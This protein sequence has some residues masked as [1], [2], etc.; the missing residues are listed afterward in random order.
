MA[1]QLNPKWDDN[2]I[3]FPRLLAEIAAAIEFTP[4]QDQALC[5]AMDLEMN[6]VAELFDRAQAE[7]DQIKADTKPPTPLCHHCGSE[8]VSQCRNGRWYCGTCI[9]SA[10]RLPCP[11]CDERAKAM[12]DGDATTTCLGCEQTYE[13]AD[14]GHPRVI[15]PTKGEPQPP[16]LTD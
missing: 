4:E 9:W 6:E 15:T 16:C 2:R 11:L 12:V 13:W 8:T 3:Q 1:T 5:E 14:A 7:W 10:R